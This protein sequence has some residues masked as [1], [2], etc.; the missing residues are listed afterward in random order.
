MKYIVELLDDEMVMTGYA[1]DEH[2]VMDSDQS[3]Y[4]AS[5]Q[6]HVQCDAKWNVPNNEYWKYTNHTP[7]GILNW[8]TYCLIR[9]IRGI[10][11]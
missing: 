7:T 4:V 1:V 5:T 6:T 10:R 3:Y 11:G 2:S 8:Y 9:V